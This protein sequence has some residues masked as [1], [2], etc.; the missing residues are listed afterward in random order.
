MVLLRVAAGD[1]KNGGCNNK[2]NRNEA[3]GERSVFPPRVSSVMSS[4]LVC[5][6]VESELASKTT[7]AAG[8]QQDQGSWWMGVAVTAGLMPHQL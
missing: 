4:C 1:G 5:V 3:G 2:H 7:V 6:V 8:G